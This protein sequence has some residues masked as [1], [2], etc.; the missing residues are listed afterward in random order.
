MPPVFLPFNLTLYSLPHAQ[1]VQRTLSP[2]IAQSPFP[3]CALLAQHALSLLSCHFAPHSLPPFAATFVSPI[4]HHHCCLFGKSN[5]LSPSFLPTNRLG[6][7]AP[8]SRRES[9]TK[10]LLCHWRYLPLP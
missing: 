2:S 4:P 10:E 9:L 6:I 5:L 7:L 3:I 1:Q 8:F